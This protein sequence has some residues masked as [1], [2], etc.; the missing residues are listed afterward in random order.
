M[1]R[2]DC[3]AVVI[4]AGIAGLGAAL[5]LEEHGAKVRVLEAQQRTGGRIHSMRQ[6]GTNAEAGATYIGAG[7]DRFIAL[8]ERFSIP[9]ID[10]TPVLEFFREQELV[11]DGEIIRQADWPAHPKN[12]FPERDR[13][14]M[15]WRYHRVLTM[16]DNPLARPEDWLAGEHAALD[17]SMREWMRGLG[18]SDAVVDIG[19]GINT[20]FGRNADDVSAL[21]M[22]FRAAFSKDQRKHAP[23]ETIG[24]TVENGVERV[25]D[26][27]AA[28]LE[29]PV[30]LGAEAVAIESNRNGAVVELADGRR[31]TARHVVCAVPFSALRRIAI[32]PPLEG[33]QAEAVAELAYQPIT[34]VYLKPKR[35][36]W[37]DDGHAASVYTDTLAGMV[38]AV[39]R[40]D[41]PSTVNHLSSWVIGPHAERLAGVGD[42]EAG[43]AVIDAIEA[44]RPAAR[45]QL[46]LIGLKAWGSDPYAGGA[47]AYFRPGQV[48]RFAAVMGRPHGRI[49][50]CGE[51]L[52]LAGRGLEGA[53]ET[54]E[55]A[56]AGI[57][58]G[59]PKGSEPK[60]L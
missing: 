15:P 18:L 57:L 33:A 25:P 4:G 34:Q 48:T 49:R 43:Q 7:Y 11:L 54:A 10:V 2:L 21:M 35:P 24:L 14:L 26:A 41:D 36:F 20:T 28:A 56:V 51:H 23:G 31:V 12:P 5:A 53:L 58:E 46:E 39:R 19:Y 37:D 29:T 55:A 8:A 52:A 45:G 9:L 60:G 3:D 44:F 27:I 32:D 1:T 17:V 22:L 6:L 40:G 30:E 16:R 50:F 47:W 42:A 38:A 59:S 13:T